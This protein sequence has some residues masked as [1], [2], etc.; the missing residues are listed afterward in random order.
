MTVYETD[1]PGVGKKFEV[2]LDEDARLV[3]VI[4]NTG[5][6]EL[7]L[8]PSPDADSEK[9]FELSDRQAREVGTIMEGAYFQPVEVGTM[10]TVL[11]D[12]TLI[13]WLTVPPESA[14]VG[15]TLADAGIRSETGASIIAI[16]RADETETNPDPETTLRA[17]D[18]LLVL[19]TREHCRAVHDLVEPDGTDADADGPAG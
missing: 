8:R 19:G 5:K 13:E 15:A 6:R 1:I 9:L 12:D 3:V 14:L 4:H 16:K 2:E 11:D 10:D 17:G 18:T 7:F